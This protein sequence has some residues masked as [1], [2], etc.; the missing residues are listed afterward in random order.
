MLVR[1]VGQ[2]NFISL[3]D[4]GGR[5]VLHF[6][7][8]FPI[9]FNRHTF[10]SRFDI[11][12]NEGPPIILSHWDWGHLHAAFHHPPLLECRWIV[13][14]QRLGPGAAQLARI[15]AQRGNLFVHPKNAKVRFAFGELLQSGGPAAD[16]NDSGLT[17]FVSLVS[18][19]SVLLL[20]DTDYTHVMLGNAKRVDHLFAT[21]HGAHFD[22]KAA[23][24]PT[25][26]K[27][28]LVI[29]YG[30]RNIYRHPP[31]SVD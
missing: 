23:M 6:D 4:H 18:G 19:R 13:P 20:G 8:G 15:L 7:V 14:D 28:G 26:N 31:G 24:I 25:P 10:P 9:S 11:D 30:Y 17:L 1:D 22:A 3:C 12:N 21:H 29:S 5:A 16:L 2:A 27:G